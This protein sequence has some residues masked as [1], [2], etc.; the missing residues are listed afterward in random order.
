MLFI[1]RKYFFEIYFIILISAYLLSLMKPC[2]LPCTNTGA[3]N[4][5]CVIS[6]ISCR[7]KTGCKQ[8]YALKHYISLNKATMQDSLNIYKILNE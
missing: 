4:L 5:N 7:S 6:V 3:K 8:K 2:L 1:N